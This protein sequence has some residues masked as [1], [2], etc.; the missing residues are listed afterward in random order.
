MTGI[1]LETVISMIK[2]ELEACKSFQRN[3]TK[4]IA[5]LR[6]QEEDD[7][8]ATIGKSI[9]FNNRMIRIH[10]ERADALV[11]AGGVKDTDDQELTIE[12]IRDS[13]D[14]LDYIR[15]LDECLEEQETEK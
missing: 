6:N 12:S 15:L 7:A 2:E 8:A 13:L 3:I 14:F 9:A 1:K 4:Q 11:K 10:L 5:A